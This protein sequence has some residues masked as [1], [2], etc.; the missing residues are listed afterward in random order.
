MEKKIFE[1]EKYPL[2]SETFELIGIGMEV[3]RT[4]GHGFLEIVYKDAIEL[5]LRK[6]LIPYER[7]KKFEIDYKGITLP[8]SYFSDFIVSEK[9]ILEVKAQEGIADEHYKQLINYLKAS[10]CKIG[11]IMNFGESSLKYKRVIL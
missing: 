11:L 1:E 7:E 9:I 8:H 2:Q 10:G 5:E 3:H 6:K 4:L